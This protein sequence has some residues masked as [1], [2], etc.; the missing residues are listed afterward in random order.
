MKLTHRVSAGALSSGMVLLLAVW[1]VSPAAATV[2]NDRDYRFGGTGSVD[3]S[4]GAIVGEGNPVGYLF[5][6][7]VFT[8]DETGP[9]AGAA[10]DIGGFIDLIVPGASNLSHSGATY[11]DTSARPLGVAGGFG[12]QFDGTD[13][14]LSNLALDIPSEFASRLPPPSTYPIEYAGIS[15]RGLQMWVRP[16]SAALPGGANAGTR[17]TIIQDTVGSGGIA[18]T[19]DGHWSQIFDVEFEDSDFPALVPVVGDTWVHA[20]HHFYTD[21]DA[22]SPAFVS[23]GNAGFYGVVYIDGVAV[24]ATNDSPDP[25]DYT[26]GDRVGLLTVGAAEIA[27]QNGDPMTAEYGEFFDGTIDDLEMYVFGDNTGAGGQDYGTFDLFSD[28]EWIANEIATTVPGGILALGDVNKDGSV[29]IAGDVPAFVAGWMSQ[30]L[31]EGW[32]G[33]TMTVGDW[34]TW[35]QGDMNL[36]GAVNLLDWAI[37]NSANPALGAAISDALSA[38]PE[39]SSAILIGMALLGMGSVRRQRL[40]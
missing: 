16:D 26:A 8:A 21:G 35:G 3:T 28:N 20:M 38:V 40:A 7:T 31:L 29:T 6:G 15:T 2:S 30:N 17:Q 22:G 18:I 34:N 36:D 9:P 11:T 37:I 5:S 33:K 14:V 32:G 24:S 25:G 12:V 39:P 27:D 10:P 1:L 13:D 4:L 23:G 19:A